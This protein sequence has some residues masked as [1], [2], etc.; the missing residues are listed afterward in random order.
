MAHAKSEGKCRNSIVT[1]FSRFKLDLLGYVNIT[2][3]EF[4]TLFTLRLKPSWTEKEQDIVRDFAARGCGHAL[5]VLY[6]TTKPWV[7]MAKVVDTT[8]PPM[9]RSALQERLSVLEKSCKAGNWTRDMYVSFLANMD[10][11][12]RTDEFSSY[13]KLGGPIYRDIIR[14]FFMK[15]ALEAPEDVSS[16][17]KSSN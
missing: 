7:L 11:P 1:H 9:H 13:Y 10:S 2:L 14:E 12:K 15:L 8:Q 3:P 5:S 17:A 16:P 6:K 4:K